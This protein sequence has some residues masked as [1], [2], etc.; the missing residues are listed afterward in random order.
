LGAASAPE[1]IPS[2]ELSGDLSHWAEQ[3]VLL[4]NSVLTV[5]ADQPGSHS[6]MG[7]QALTD[8]IISKASESHEHVVFIL[9]GAFAQKKAALI[10]SKRHLILN[11][12]HPSPLSAHRGF[13]G[14]RPFS[15]TN[16]YLIGH[17]LK[18]I[19]WRVP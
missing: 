11:S 18:P 13:F 14:S 7:W 17:G 9:W 10:D 3:G 15:Q 12:V 6:R 5:R 4:L 19:D 16:R 2:R 8:L 1:K